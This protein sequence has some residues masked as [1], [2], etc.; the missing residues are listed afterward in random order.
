MSLR[1]LKAVWRYRKPGHRAGSRQVGIAF[2]PWLGSFWT[3]QRCPISR[4]A[5]CPASGGDDRMCYPCSRT[6]GTYVPGLTQRRRMGHPRAP[7]RPRVADAK[8]PRRYYCPAAGR[9]N[10]V[11]RALGGLAYGNPAVDSTGASRVAS[12]PASDCSYARWALVMRL[13]WLTLASYPIVERFRMRSTS[14]RLLR[15]A[16]SA[17]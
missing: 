8:E 11:C 13:V 17:S 10:R 4:R 12:A 6:P 9:R 5:R 7:R 14:N 3:I 16:T 2:R 1:D 15:F